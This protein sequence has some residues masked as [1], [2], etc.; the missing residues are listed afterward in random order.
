MA[1]SDRVLK[2]LDMYAV[3][4]LGAAAIPNPSAEAKIIYK[5]QDIRITQGYQC[6]PSHCIAYTFGHHHDPNFVLRDLTSGLYDAIRFTGF[7]QKHSQAVGTYSCR[8]IRCPSYAAAPVPAGAVIGNK[9]L[10]GDPDA[11]MWGTLHTSG[12]QRYYGKWKAPTDAYL[13]FRFQFNDKNRAKNYGW[14]HVVVNKHSVHATGY[15]Y[16]TVPG[17]SI[18]AGDIGHPGS[19]TLS[20]LARGKTRKT[21]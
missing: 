10:F 18:R 16:E 20:D 6:D 3:A 2:R 12:N 5:H 21:P 9:A 19:G 1:L 7:P 14:L 15:A 11:L 17:K 4:A 8:P 13:G